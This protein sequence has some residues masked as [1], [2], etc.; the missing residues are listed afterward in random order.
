MLE[1]IPLHHQLTL[2]WLSSITGVVII[3]NSDPARHSASSN[4]VVR[5]SEIGLLLKY[6]FEDI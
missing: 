1:S 4:S 6:T 5:A 2:E 3:A